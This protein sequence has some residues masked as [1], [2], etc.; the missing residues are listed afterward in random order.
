MDK[1]GAYAAQEHAPLLIDR[2]EGSV[3]NVI[4]LPVERIS[5][6]LRLNGLLPES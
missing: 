1:A 5:E 3:N 2:I 6:T 4:G